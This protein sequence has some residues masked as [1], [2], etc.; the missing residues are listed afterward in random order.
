MKALILTV[1]LL[2]TMLLGLA[3]MFFF[4]SSEPVNSTASDPQ[5]TASAVTKKDDGIDRKISEPY[6]GELSIFE[7]PERDDNLQ[8]N[9]VMD[10]LQI[11]DKKV[12]ADIGAGSGWFSVRAAKR[13]GEKGQ[14]FAVEINQEYVDHINKRAKA[15]KLLNIKTVV[16]KTDDPLLPKASVDS[17]LILK[18]YHEISE[19]IRFLKN[20][21]PALRREALVGIIDRNGIGDDHGIAK[22]TVIDE[23]KL[24]G[25]S[26]KEEFDFVKG[27]GMDYFLVFIVRR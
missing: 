21:K 8:I 11:S 19:P 15:E 12:V 18:T 26:L 25:F 1:A 13:V 20:L 6:A 7:E 10:I 3:W 14:V 9:R 27:D 16:G 5:P 23:A 17:V 24:A 22:Q 2:K 4:P